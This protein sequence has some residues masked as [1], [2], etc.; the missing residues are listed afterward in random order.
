MYGVD[1]SLP[2]SQHV[3]R[4]IRPA[5]AS[6]THA[7]ALFDCLQIGQTHAHFALRIRNRTDSMKTIDSLIDFFDRLA[8]PRMT[9]AQIEIIEKKLLSLANEY[10][11]EAGGQYR[12]RPEHLDA[13]VEHF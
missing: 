9:N 11:V 7:A 13:P 2:L 6:P 5:H 4:V 8:T 12:K 1:E 10:N 3:R